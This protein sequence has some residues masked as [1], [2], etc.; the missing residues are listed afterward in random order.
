MTDGG[1]DQHFRQL[2]D[3]DTK[4]VHGSAP[5]AI[6]ATLS[7]ASISMVRSSHRASR[8]FRPVPSQDFGVTSVS[9]RTSSGPRSRDADI[10]RDTLNCCGS[11]ISV[12]RVFEFTIGASRVHKKQSRQDME[13]LAREE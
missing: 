1:Y 6:L 13:V 3:I 9:T 4:V 8:K 12:D 5:I 11:L 2:P 10:R 7:N